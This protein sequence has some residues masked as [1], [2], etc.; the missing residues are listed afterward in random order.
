MSCLFFG[1]EGGCESHRLRRDRAEDAREFCCP[2]HPLQGHGRT[3]TK[4]DGGAL[5]RLASWRGRAI[6]AGGSPVPQH[7][8]RLQETRRGYRGGPG[9]SWEA[10]LSP[11]SAW[12]QKPELATWA[13]G[14]AMFMC[15]CGTLTLHRRGDRPRYPSKDPQSLS[16]YDFLTFCPRDWAASWT[17]WPYSE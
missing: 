2:W 1:G 7:P 8:R 9:H 15:V 13:A 14:Q 12:P 17:P 16:P 6:R 5:P 10:G 11:G 4:E 3:R